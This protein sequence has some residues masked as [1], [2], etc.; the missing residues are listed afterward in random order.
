MTTALSR[1][2]SA[3]PALSGSYH[4]PGTTGYMPG[5]ACMTSA[6]HASPGRR[7]APDQTADSLT[8]AGCQALRCVLTQNQQRAIQHFRCSQPVRDSLSP[9]AGLMLRQMQPDA[10][11]A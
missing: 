6:K 10:L 9:L 7:T 3:V 5:P 2:L 8:H 4:G 1:R 11:N